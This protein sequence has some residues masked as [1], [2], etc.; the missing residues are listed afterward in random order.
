MVASGMPPLPVSLRPLDPSEL[1]TVL[2]RVISGYAGARVLAVD[3]PLADAERN[4]RVQTEALLP[5]GLATPGH[6]LYGVMEGEVTVGHLWLAISAPDGFPIAFLYDITLRE[7]ARGR[8]LGRQVMALAEDAARSLGARDLE[9]H[10][11][12]HNA[13]ARRLYELVG[14]RVTSL[15]M[16]KTFGG[17]P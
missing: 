7:D 12:A 17:P 11:F 2:E 10:V 16:R 8:G 6:H 9:L 1:I 4:A 5:N 3:A 14:Y 13:R 15:M